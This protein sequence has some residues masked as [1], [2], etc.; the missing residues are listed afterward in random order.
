MY[1]APL[2]ILL[3]LCA[4]STAGADPGRIEI[5]RFSDGLIADW[6]EK[7]FSGVTR[8]DLVELDGARVLRAVSDDSASGLYREQRIDLERTPWL[9]WSW[10]MEG[11][12]NPGNEQAR[13]GDDYAGRVYVVIS[14]GMLFWKTR[15]LNYVWSSATARNVTWPNA[16]AGKSAMMM[17]VRTA[18]DDTSVWYNEKRNVLADLKAVFGED[19][20][21]IDAV[22]VMT[23]TDN[24]HGRVTS[25]YGDLY[26]TAR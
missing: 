14:G 12:L 25:Y 18:D 11:R 19:I 21:Y 4:V 23:D 13:S 10:R 5:G 22:A 24:T 26:F 9:N 6:K 17:A 20:R 3:L 16:F 1:L 15:A 8:Y 7:R 2:Y